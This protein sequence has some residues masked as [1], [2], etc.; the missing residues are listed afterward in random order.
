MAE[1]PERLVPKARTVHLPDATH[2][3]QNSAPEEVNR[4][5]LEFLR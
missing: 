1:P 5:L 3:V 4:L 2:W